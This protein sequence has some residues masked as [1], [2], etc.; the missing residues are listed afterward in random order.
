MLE[1]MYT[2][3]Y[4]SRTIYIII[5]DENKSEFMLGRGQNATLQHNDISI[6]RGHANISFTD[7]KWM[8]NDNTSKF[9]T[10]VLVKQNCPL[11]QGYSKSVQIGRTILN[12]SLKSIKPATPKKLNIKVKKISVNDKQTPTPSTTSRVTRRKAI[13]KR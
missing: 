1:S 6:S 8:L 10:L 7:G 13:A 5:P 9:G 3:K 4:S 11:I 2:E 12:C